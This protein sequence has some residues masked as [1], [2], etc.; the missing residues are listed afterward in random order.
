MK[1]TLP[2]STISFNSPEFLAIKLDELATA[3]ILSFWSFIVHH[4]E[5]DEGGKK[6]HIHL[7][8]E[9]AKSIQTVDLTSELIEFD[10]DHPEKP[11]KCISWV[12]SKFAPWYLYALHDK[13]YLAS[14]GQSR[15]FHYSHDEILTSDPDDLH[16]K[17]KSID[18]L[19]LSPYADMLEAQSLGLSWAEYFSRGTVPIMQIA[20]FERAWQ[21][22]AQTATD[23]NGRSDHPMDVDEETDRSAA[24]SS[25]TPLKRSTTSE[26]KS[27]DQLTAENH[28][29]A[30]KPFFPPSR[31]S[32]YEVHPQADYVELDP[33]EESPF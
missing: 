18:M 19:S 2:I 21:T 27:D 13:R 12:K 25:E 1:T 11:K 26:V 6:E 9:P 33:D 23:R 14:Q 30:Q 10:P 28:K 3:K 8:V 5:D 16:S 22:L 17:A 29:D 15:R 7:Y 20:Q 24:T 4:P 32:Y 31:P